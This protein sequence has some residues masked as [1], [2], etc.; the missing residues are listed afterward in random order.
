MRN[1][2]WFLPK[3]ANWRPDSFL[4]ASFLKNFTRRHKQR[5]SRHDDFCGRAASVGGTRWRT[6]SN[7]GVN[8]Q[9]RSADGEI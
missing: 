9:D 6:V 3:E 5:Y 7:G 2:Y 8:A 4:L 1:S